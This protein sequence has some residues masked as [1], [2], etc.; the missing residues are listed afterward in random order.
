M[1]R[2]LFPVQLKM[3]TDI[4]VK[5]SKKILRAV[6]DPRRCGAKR[7]LWLINFP[8]WCE[9]WRSRWKIIRLCNR[10]EWS[11]RFW[12]VRVIQPRAFCRPSG[13]PGCSSTELRENK[14]SAKIKMDSSKVS[15]KVFV[16][17]DACWWRSV[18]I[19]SVVIR[20]RTRT[21]RKN[22]KFHFPRWSRIFLF[23]KRANDL[24]RLAFQSRFPLKRTFLLCA[25]LDDVMIA[26]ELSRGSSGY[27]Y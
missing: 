16:T 23:P 22:R 8:R 26:F 24:L 4:F 19:R 25:C 7:C 11:A 3:M 1:P 14:R 2:S 21:F 5:V 17:K 27:L 9:R 20:R 18:V 15:E 12:S 6:T 10:I 13:P